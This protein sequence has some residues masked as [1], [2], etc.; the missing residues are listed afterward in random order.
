MF[1]SIQKYKFFQLLITITFLIFNNKNGEKLL[2]TLT[3]FK[4]RITKINRTLEILLNNTIKIDR[5]ILNLAIE[6]FPNKLSDLPNNILNLL[7]R[8]HNF[9]IYWV[10]KDI[11]VFK[12]LIPT[13][14]RFKN[15]LIVTVDDDILYPRD[16]LEKMLNCYKKYGSRYPVSFGGPNSDWNINGHLIYSHFGAG[17]IVKYKYFNDKMKIL[18]EFTTKDLINKGIKCFDDVLYTYSALLNGYHYKRC[19]EYSISSYIQNSPKLPNPF[20]Q[21]YN[22]QIRKLVYNYHNIIQSFIKIKY[23]ININDLVKE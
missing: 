17:S 22:K 1:Q 12:K 14:N 5:L 7:K 23:N 11:K 15:D 6:E 3:S 9:E 4:D 21:N 16:M 13:I 8:Y 10:E 2:V 19:K 20:S 18:Y